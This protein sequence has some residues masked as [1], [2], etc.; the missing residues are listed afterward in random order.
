MVTIFQLTD[1]PSESETVP[2]SPKCKVDQYIFTVHK[3]SSSH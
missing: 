3:F 2:T 1:W